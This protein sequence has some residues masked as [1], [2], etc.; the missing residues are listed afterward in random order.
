MAQF[1]SLFFSNFIIERLIRDLC[2]HTGR[3]FTRGINRVN[4]VSSLFPIGVII[5]GI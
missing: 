4:K 2:T 5:K 3:T 1:L